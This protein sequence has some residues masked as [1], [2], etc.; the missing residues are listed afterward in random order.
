MRVLQARPFAPWPSRCPCCPL[1][2]LTLLLLVSSALHASAQFD[3]GSFFNNALKDVNKAVNDRRDR[4]E[5]TP[6]ADIVGGIGGI[7]N[8]VGIATAILEEGFLMDAARHVAPEDNGQTEAAFPDAPHSTGWD[9]A[10]VRLILP[11]GTCTAEPNF[12]GGRP[13]GRPPV[14]FGGGGSNFG[15]GGANFGGGAKPPVNFGGGGGSNFGGGGGSPV[16]FPGGGPI[17]RPPVTTKPPTNEKL[18][19]GPL[20][21]LAWVNKLVV[22]KDDVQIPVPFGGNERNF[23]IGVGQPDKPHQDCLT[24]RSEKGK[25]RFLEHCIQ[26]AFISDFRAYLKYA[27]FIQGRY[28]GVCCPEAPPPTPPTPPPVTKPPPDPKGTNNCTLININKQ[29]C[30]ISNNFETR[31]VGGRPADPKDWPWMAALLR[32]QTDNYCGGALITNKHVLTASHC[33]Q[34]Y[35]QNQ[36]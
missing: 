29:G 18:I 22:T 26:P 25:C 10:D 13:G 24:P 35:V 7:L 16:V 5:P 8:N 2:L 12:N 20:K 23:P 33:V 36:M 1:P 15:G 32:D 9:A 34:P 19:S 31:I 30:G 21:E 27:C 4:N 11:D 6:V 14:N 17:T 28:L 3:L